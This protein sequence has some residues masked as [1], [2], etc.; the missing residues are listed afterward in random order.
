MNDMT[1]DPIEKQLALLRKRMQSDPAAFRQ[2]FLTD[3][4]GAAAWEF[5]QDELSGEFTKTFWE[6]LLR[7]DD[8][9]TVL[10]RFVWAHDAEGEAQIHPRYRQAPVGPLPDVQRAVRGLAR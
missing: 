3:G 7:G 10:Q 9:S 1:L 4:M 5:K 8:A 2:M 6:L